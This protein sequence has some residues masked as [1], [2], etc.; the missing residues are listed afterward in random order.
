MEGKSLSLSEIEKMSYYDFMGYL[1]VPFFQI[2]GLTSTRKLAELCGI[3]EK[4]KVLVVGCGTGFNACY[5]ARTFGCTL[6]GVDLAKEAVEKARDRA[7]NQGLDERVEFRVGDAYD[8]P[9]EADSFD[10]VVTQFVAQ[11][12]DMGKALA[13]FARVLRPGGCVGLNEIFRDK[14]VAPEIS[15]KI[16]EAERIICEITDLPFRIHTPEDWKGMLD[17]ASLKGIEVREKKGTMSMREGLDLLGQMGGF[18]SVC[19]LCGRMMKFMVFSSVIR[20][21]FMK[22]DKAKR[23]MVQSPIFATPASKHIGYILGIGKKG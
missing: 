7:K 15:D 19:V 22:L 12:L 9:F 20:K 14:D 3:D 11:F 21:R 4:K 23:I 10:V 8:L 16:D 17:G 13:E 5:I 1:G 2:G 18:W 6:V